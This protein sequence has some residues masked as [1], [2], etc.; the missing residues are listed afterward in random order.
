MFSACVTS[1]GRTYYTFKVA[2][3]PDISYNIALMG[4]WAST[5]LAIGTIVSC[6]PVLPRFFQHLGPKVSG[7]FSFTSKSENKSTPE[8]ASAGRYKTTRASLAQRL[9]FNKRRTGSNTS[10]LWS[11]PSNPQLEH[12]GACV[13]PRD[14]DSGRLES[15]VLD[16]LNETP[17]VRSTSLRQ[18]DLESAETGDAIE[19][20]RYTY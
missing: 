18:D 1:I 14:Y 12:N 11:G 8:L 15:G 20:V 6:L 7:I 4:L 9:S 10:V 3:L 2:Q 17:S 13:T 16:G 5:E 19:M